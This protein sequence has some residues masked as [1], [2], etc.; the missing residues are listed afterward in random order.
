MERI[1]GVDAARGLAVL[2]MVTAHVGPSSE[3]FWSPAGWLAVADGRSAA[4]FALLAGVSAALLSGGPDPVIG[5]R[6]VQART[7]ILVRAALLFV[8]GGLVTML[9]TP[10]AVILGHYALY[11]AVV[12]A[13][14]RWRP[15]ELLLVAAGFAVLGPPICFTIAATLAQEQA[16][17]TMLADLVVGPY[18][19]AG[20]WMAYVLTGLAVGRLDLWSRT[21]RLRLAGAG[22][23]LAVVGYVGSRI[24][25]A[26]F[27]GAS[28][29]TLQLLRADPHDNTMFEVVGNTGV[30]LVVLAVLL[31]AAERWPRMLFPLI[32][33]GALALTVY[34]GHIFVIAALGSDVVWHAT[35]GTWLA[36]LV[37]ILVSASL[38]RA[39]VG[40][41]PLER[42]LHWVST[43]AADVWPDVLPER[44]ARTEPAGQGAP[45]AEPLGQA[46]QGQTSPRSQEPST[47]R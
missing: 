29:S 4:T 41:G 31:V 44:P 42:V 46:P 10:V 22:A 33:T 38:W 34:V 12:V 32:A 6:L 43:R 26:A 28:E 30:A 3:V 14:L 20:I 9:G 11:F 24:A 18:Y 37:V 47:D 1:T 36:F 39:F 25:L 23:A 7:R 5:T 16:R 17:P 40:R 8:L 13:F 45:A 2:G 19:P 27:A 21:V 35:A 15:R